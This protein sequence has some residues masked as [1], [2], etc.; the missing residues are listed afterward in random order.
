M[1]VCA[2]SSK[3][4]SGNSILTDFYGLTQVKA[5][6]LTVTSPFFILWKKSCTTLDGWRP[7]KKW[8]Q[9]PINWCRI[10]ST[11]SIISKFLVKI[12]RCLGWISHVLGKHMLKGLAPGEKTVFVLRMTKAWS[13]NLKSSQGL[14]FLGE[15]Q[16]FQGFSSPESSMGK[17]TDL[18]HFGHERWKILD[19]PGFYSTFFRSLSTAWNSP[20]PGSLKPRWL[21][22]VGWKCV[23]SPTWPMPWPKLLLQILGKWEL[24]KYNYM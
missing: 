21:V 17:S 16:F 7:I 18:K 3:S 13:R 11:H 15:L 12:P 20:P 1:G 8:G 23:E 9:S 5:Q 14:S 6:C 10:S 2:V 19:F 4:W 22:R 24:S